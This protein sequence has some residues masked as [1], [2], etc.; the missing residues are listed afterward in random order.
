MY[1]T[2]HHPP[3]ALSSVGALMDPGFLRQVLHD[4]EEQGF[5]AEPV[6]PAPAGRFR[7]A[8]QV[9]ASACL[10]RIAPH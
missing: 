10:R 3:H 4:A 9:F 7:A 5:S 8:V 2:P 1:T 6:L